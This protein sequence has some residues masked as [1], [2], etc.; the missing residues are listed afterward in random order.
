MLFFQ[1]EQPQDVQM[2]QQEFPKK[3]VRLAYD[4]TPLYAMG[5]LDDRA[6]IGVRIFYL[7]VDGL[8]LGEIRNFY[9]HA[10]F[11]ERENTALV[12]TLAQQ[13][14]FDGTPRHVTVDARQILNQHLRGVDQNRIVK[15]RISFEIS[16]GLCES[17][18]EANVDNVSVAMEE[19]V[20]PFRFTREILLEMTET[21]LALYAKEPQK[22]PES[23]RKAIFDQYGH[24][25]ITGWLNEIPREVRGDLGRLTEYL[26]HRYK[27]TGKDA[28]M[29]GYAVTLLLQTQ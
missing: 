18:V 14:P 8:I 1:Y 21:S 22:H 25:N 28:W 7:D 9:Y 16:S 11:E 6:W 26:V 20:V 5:G 13:G 17:S 10:V 3:V 23:A 4:F 12:H 19:I 2:A 15:T 29:S 24:K 27:V